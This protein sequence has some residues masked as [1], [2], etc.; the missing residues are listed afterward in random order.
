MKIAYVAD[1]PIP[2]Q[3]ANCVQILSMASA[4]AATGA[5]VRLFAPWRSQ[6]VRGACEFSALCARFAVQE[7]FRLSY[8]P[9]PSILGRLGGSYFWLA[10]LGAKAHRP[11]LVITRSLRIADA[12]TRLGLRVVVELH[13]PPNS[14]RGVAVLRALAARPLLLRWVFISDQLRRIC[15]QKAQASFRSCLVLHDAVN[16]DRFRPPLTKAQARHGIGAPPDA[17]LVV[18][19]GSLYEGRGAETLLDVAATMPTTQF[20]FVGG[21]AA[22]IERINKRLAASRVEN[23]R[24]LGHRTVQ[25]LP[26]YL[27]A[28]DVLVA[29]MTREG[30]M[31]D[32]KTITVDY[33]SPMKLFE[34]M[35]AGRPIVASRFGGVSEVL[36]H[37]ENAWLFEPGSVPELRGAL[38]ELSKHP[39]LEGA[40]ASRASADIEHYTWPSRAKQMLADL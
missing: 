32:R 6:R 27:F 31:V 17:R 19:S 7:N 18:H 1:N 8:L 29:P 3:A 11:D 13:A 30:C 9:A 37:R 36:R 14:D 10:A 12:C 24:L 2:S 40:L 35:A 4:L 16:L 28:A 23:V 5:S 33:A 26:P 39:E 38:Q 22:D 34:Y 20:W 21:V 15:A 25:A